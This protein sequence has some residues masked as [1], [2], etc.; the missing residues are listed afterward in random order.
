MR[1]R[2]IQ[3]GRLHF[4]HTLLDWVWRW[5]LG[6]LAYRRRVLYVNENAAH[7]L[8]GAP[9]RPDRQAH[10]PLLPSRRLQPVR[11]AVAPAR[12]AP[13]PGRPRRRL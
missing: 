13:A 4:H 5:P 6:V 11:Q 9:P 8:G 3:L 1:N 10:R 2:S 7:L 12:H